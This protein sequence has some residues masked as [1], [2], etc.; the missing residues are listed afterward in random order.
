MAYLNH[1]FEL[2][3]LTESGQVEGLA[4]SFGGVDVY[5][6]TVATGAYAATLA[7][8]KA[9]GT[10]PA[11]LLHHDL[12]RP[13]GRWDTLTETPSGLVAKGKLALDATDGRE[14][15]ALLKAEAIT[16]LSIGF[17]SKKAEQ[18]PGGGRIFREIELYE[19]SLVSIPADWDARI[20]Q[21]K[22]FAG[23]GELEA[24]F[25]SAGASG[26]KSKAAASAAWRELN[27]PDAEEDEREA[28]A[29]ILRRWTLPDLTK[30]LK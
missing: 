11:M 23:P 6:D 28:L 25:R 27:G 15:Y 29:E 18:K 9:K 22:S 30:G 13:A 1:H 2:K 20:S 4:S 12:A 10:M 14:A 26:R 21:V 19:V 8:H 7:A 17:N 5:G 24:L 16:G 3:S